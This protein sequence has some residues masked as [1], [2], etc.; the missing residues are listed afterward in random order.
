MSEHVGVLVEAD[1]GAG[2]LHKLT[3]PVREISFQDRI[4]PLP[5]LLFALGR[6]LRF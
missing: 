1:P 3:G 6:L 5:F 2:I 4:L